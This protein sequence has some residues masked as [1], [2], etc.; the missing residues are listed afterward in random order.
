MGTPCQEQGAFA[1]HAG[2]GVEN[3]DVLGEEELQLC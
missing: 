1:A 3:E 2:N